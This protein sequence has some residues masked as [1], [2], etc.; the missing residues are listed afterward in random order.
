MDFEPS[1]GWLAYGQAH[2]TN[3]A[4]TSHGYDLASRITT[5]NNVA[6]LY[7]Y[8]ALGRE[9]TIPAIDMQNTQNTV[10]HYFADDSIQAITQGAT[11]TSYTLDPAGRQLAE[12]TTTATGTTTVERHYTDTSQAP[13]FSITSGGVN[14]GTTVYLPG[15]AGA[16]PSITGTDGVNNLQIIDPHGDTV[17]TVNTSG[18][19]VLNGWSQ[20][21]EY[22]NQQT[23]TQN[24]KNGISYGWAG[25]AEK[26]TTA[27]GLILMGARVYDSVTGRFT[28]RDPVPGGNE[29]AYSYPNDPINVN[30]W[31]GC[32]AAQGLF[33]TAMGAVA[34]AMFLACPETAFIGC[35]VGATISAS[36]WGAA[37]AG[38]TDEGTKK[39]PAEK[40]KD[41]I[42][43]AISGGISRTAG[44]LFGKYF[45]PQ[46]EPNSK[47]GQSFVK[48]LVAYGSGETVKTL[49]HPP[50]QKP[51]Q[52][53][54]NRRH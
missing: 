9:T 27:S 52:Q 34:G 54:H 53:F 51:S 4:T 24:P 20:Y 36:I 7:T 50:S 38:A 23:G 14:A 21:D 33:V 3:Q 11:S 28:S 13:S 15:L 37:A 6:G 45:A 22:G 41:L 48:G 18:T 47:F 43:G 39:T 40:N 25:S 46:L 17:A 10:L 1:L 5:T 26:A 49:L 31:S 12:T 42:T 30:D 29:T 35:L 19:P 44:G 32:D 8:D 16:M 2:A